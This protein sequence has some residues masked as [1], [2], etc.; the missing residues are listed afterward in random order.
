MHVDESTTSGATGQGALCSHTGAHRYLIALGSNLGERAQHLNTALAYIAADVGPVTAVAP[1]YETQPVGGAADQLFLNSAA[2]CVSLMSP[3][4][5][6]E[7]LLAVET[8]LGRVRRQHWGNRVIDLDLLLWQPRGTLPGAR[9]GV[10]AT[11]SLVL[12]HPRMLERDFVLVPAADV[13]GDWVHPILGQTLATERM[14]RGY[15]LTEA[16]QMPHGMGP[17]W[18]PAYAART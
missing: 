15:H 13:A 12:P 1:Y 8:L 17:A 18:A 9:A 3:P 16:P 5:V 4:R 6:L 11:T 7:A 10:L 14:L 2:V